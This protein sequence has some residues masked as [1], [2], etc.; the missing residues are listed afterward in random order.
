MKNEITDYR[1]AFRQTKH[2]SVI[3]RDFFTELRSLSLL[4][5]ETGPLAW[6][7]TMGYH[8][9]PS[10]EGCHC[11]SLWGLT[12]HSAWLWHCPQ[13]SSAPV[14]Q[15]HTTDRQTVTRSMP[16]SYDS[17]PT[18]FY[19]YKQICDYQLSHRRS[20]SPHPRYSY[21]GLPCQFSPSQC[22]W[23]WPEY[24]RL[25]YST[26]VSACLAPPSGQ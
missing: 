15:K 8:S 22:G 17:S 26:S 23:P 9:L 25:K 14:E 6:N 7:I 5:P 2:Y 18:L 24:H 1:L 3:L 11:A 13:S 12:S 21:V 20:F 16:I 19:T 10:P 4:V